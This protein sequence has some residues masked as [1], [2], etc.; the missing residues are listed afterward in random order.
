MVIL[1]KK[2]Q[3][4]K[5]EAKQDQKKYKKD[6]GNNQWTSTGMRNTPDNRERRDGP[7]GENVKK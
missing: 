5:M 3:K 4:A 7:G 6:E 2:Q 1:D